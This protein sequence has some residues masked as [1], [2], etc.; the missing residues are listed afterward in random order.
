MK[1]TLK[2]PI[3]L[4][5]FLL[6]VKI[7]CFA[8]N[9]RAFEVLK[10]L[11]IFSTVYKHLHL[12]YVDE[13]QP[14][15]LMKTAI[16]AM[17]QS[18]DPYTIYIP[19]ANIE[20]LRLFTENAYEGIGTLILTRDGRTF[21]SE[22][23]E[24]FPAYKAGLMVGDQIVAVNGVNIANRTNDE[25]GIL[26]RGQ[27]NTS[28]TLTIQRLGEDS[29]FEKTLI[30]EAIRFKNVT[31]SVMLAENVAYIKLDGFT[32]GAANEVKE[33]FL[34]LK[35]EG[36]TSLV[37]DLRGN[38]G[39]LMN[40]AADIVSL[41]VERGL[42]VVSMKGKIQDRNQTFSTR[43]EPVDRDIPIVVLIDRESASASE[44]VAGALQDYDRAVIIGQRSFGKGLVQNIL[45]LD[46][47]AQ[48]KITTAKYYIPSGRSVQAIDYTNRDDEGRARRV[49][50][51][52]R[53]TFQTRGGRIVY[54]G[55]GI[56]PDI[57][58][59]PEILSNI[60]ATLFGKL[61]FFDFVNDYQRKHKTLP[62]LS[63]FVVSDQLFNEFKHFLDDKDTEY[64]TQ[65]EMFLE[66]LTRAAK[67]ENY[68]D[69]IKGELELVKKQLFHDKDS[70]MDKHKAEI[71]AV[72]GLELVSR[73]YFQKG[74]AE[75]ALRT[76]TE[77]QKAIE[78]LNNL[79][80]YRNILR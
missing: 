24:G 58:L 70:D 33:S 79:E 50:D 38:G 69:A 46:Y 19:E 26:L 63:E 36:A 71:K 78:V 1:N 13:T 5:L 7:A 31:Y 68:F 60:T 10:N 64:K 80:K 55:D 8:Q 47:N 44:I 37:L 67:E 4:L 9:D 45:P 65:T 43:S 14:G 42:P 74:V 75:F 39:G 29:P 11:E 73:Y 32:E 62:N 59:E 22:I 16:D 52:L 3:F 48:L 76:D 77:V 56:E 35:N 66:I 51:S 53:T 61:H 41:F 72:L 54:D 57:E 30:R 2:K 6:N 18:L 28:L 25:V 40:E 15:Q 20:D 21:I 23:Y 27:A 12:H 17:L 34:R 49:P